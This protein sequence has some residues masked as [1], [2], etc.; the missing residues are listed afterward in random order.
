MA[1]IIIHANEGGQTEPAVNKK[2]PNCPFFL[3]LMVQIEN[4]GC[5]NNCLNDKA[6]LIYQLVT[7]R[8]KSR[9]V[10]VYACVY[11]CVYACVYACV[12]VCEWVHPY[13]GLGIHFIL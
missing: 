6:E 12:Y 11:V 8:H 2:P 4:P 5:E 3:N 9:C 10:C 13:T 7:G 1:E